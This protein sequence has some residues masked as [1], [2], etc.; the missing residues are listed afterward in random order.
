MHSI[1]NTCGAVCSYNIFRF[2]SEPLRCSCS[3]GKCSICC[4]L[5]LDWIGQDLQKAFHDIFFLFSVPLI[6]CVTCKYDTVPEAP[7]FIILHCSVFIIAFIYS[8]IAEVV[9]FCF[10]RFFLLCKPCSVVFAASSL[11]RL[12]I[13]LV[14]RIVSGD[15]MSPTV[16]LFSSQQIEAVKVRGFVERRK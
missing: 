11:F 1:G 6:S 10:F 14:G 4:M 2:S 8:A 16:V 9:H 7:T 15:C 13:F 5:A 12:P 3:L